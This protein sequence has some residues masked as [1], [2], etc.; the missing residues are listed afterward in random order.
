MDAGSTS[1]NT[2]SENKHHFSL[3]VDAIYNEMPKKKTFKE[4]QHKMMIH[5]KV[6]IGLS[7]ENSGTKAGTSE[8]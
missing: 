1:F 4:K 7:K 5:S 2:G 8:R 6:F 3:T